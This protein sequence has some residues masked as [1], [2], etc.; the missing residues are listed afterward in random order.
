MMKRFPEGWQARQPPIS[1]NEVAER[2]RCVIV[3]RL[4]AGMIAPGDRLP[5]IRE[6]A[7]QLR[8]DHRVVGE[9]YRLLEK[10]QLVVVREKSGV[11]AVAPRYLGSRKDEVMGWAAE[12]LYQAWERQ[13]SR[14][15]LCSLFGGSG[16]PP[17]RCGCVESNEDHMVALCG[18]LEAGLSVQA[19]P[20]FVEP[21]VRPED[22]PPPGLA[23]VDVVTTS[24][25]HAK[26]AAAAAAAL[27]KP[28]VVLALR[29][30]FASS[31][32]RLLEQ[33]PVT[34]VICDPRYAERAGTFMAAPARDAVRFVTVDEAERGGVDLA[35][36]RVMVT[37][38]ARRRL[39][40]EDCHLLP[41]L[42][43]LVS[44]QSQRELCRAIVDL[45]ARV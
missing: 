40:L 31:V 42:P 17:L 44:E 19:V 35:G 43:R 24:V 34:A 30:D 36:E 33:G 26:Y 11:F 1:P 12:V 32:G 39:G 18:E 5:S 45:G 22:P 10:E 20:L 13:I 23:D 16:P 38:A 9:A 25:F 3:G 6:V 28:L 8:I 29:K 14:S 21:S 2:L 15:E 37:R 27:G 7:D 4:H 41:T